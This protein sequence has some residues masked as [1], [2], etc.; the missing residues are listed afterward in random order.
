MV[1]TGLDARL[2]NT[3]NLK[4]KSN[5]FKMEADENNSDRLIKMLSEVGERVESLRDQAASIQRERENILELLQDIQD[6]ENNK[7]LSEGKLRFS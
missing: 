7:D 6:I 2:K 1:Y 5:T 3:N 4:P